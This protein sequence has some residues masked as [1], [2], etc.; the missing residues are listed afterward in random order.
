M[1]SS[2]D[3]R[4]DQVWRYVVALG[5]GPAAMAVGI[6]MKVSHSVSCGD[7]T[8]SP[9]EICRDANSGKVTTYDEAASGS[10]GVST[11]LIIIGV[12]ITLAAAAW[13]L[14]RWQNRA[15]RPLLP[16]KQA[17]RGRVH[18]TWVEARLSENAQ[19]GLA[20]R[21]SPARFRNIVAARK[22]LARH[23]DAQGQ[24]DPVYARGA[25]TMASTTRPFAPIVAP[26]LAWF[27]VVIPAKGDVKER[28]REVLA[29]RGP[30]LRELL[31]G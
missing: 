12:I 8:M 13:F 6:Y 20:V 21:V 28:M 29:E 1:A 24:G 2:G 16:P 25:A 22:G 11:F 31:Q 19:N 4:F 30:E 27:L 7:A 23:L 26:P 5:I 14:Y 15:T 18:W 9:G 10:Q 3:P 17:A